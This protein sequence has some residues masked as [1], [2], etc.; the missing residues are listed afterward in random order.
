MD[1]EK[2]L[3]ENKMEN[4]TVII[5]GKTIPATPETI[6]SRKGQGELKDIVRLVIAPLDAIK[7]V[8]DESLPYDTIAVSPKMYED[9]KKDIPD[10]EQ[11][12]KGEV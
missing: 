12:N 2:T 6:T 11:L 4:G 8:K 7:I 3:E 1:A 10:K 5:N 9:L